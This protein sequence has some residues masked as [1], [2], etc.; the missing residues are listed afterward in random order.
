MTSRAGAFL[1][2]A[3]LCPS[4]R[5]VELG[6]ITVRSYVGQQL[7]ADIEL[8]SLAPDEVAGL[9]VR[10]ALPDVFSGANIRM[11][12]ALGTVHMSVVRRDQ[13]QFLH[14]TTLQA[15]D[16]NYI[17]L[18]L[19]LG[20]PGR[21]VVRAATVWLQPD[22]HPLPPPTPAY[23][24]PVPLSA[25]ASLA[26]GE[27]LDELP[28]PRT[29]PRAPAGGAA[30]HPAASAPA[31]APA[32]AARRRAAVA[33][34]ATAAA[35]AGAKPMPP[36]V[37]QDAG[38]AACVAKSAGLSAKECVALDYR[39]AALSTKLVELEDKVKVLQYA[40]EAP[41]AA[42][43]TPPPIVPARPPGAGVATAGAAAGHAAQAGGGHAAA[44]AAAVA[45]HT[46][47]A[48]A[49]VPATAPAAHADTAAHGAAA[50]PP[51]SAVA[52]AVDPHAPPPIVAA[53]AAKH[54]PKLKYSDK[55]EKPAEP[56][57][58]TGLLAAA[59]AGA[60]ALLLVLGGLWYV[61][62]RRK[63]AGMGSAPLKIWQGWRKKKPVE[64]EQ[65]L[66]EVMPEELLEQEKS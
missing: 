8:I 16:A 65:P 59:G 51:A 7:S 61:L 35:D 26:P 29:A 17:H 47:S 58:N 44:P 57:V 38:A 55:K 48:S 28:P 21:Q 40:L 41:A 62:R 53:P 45:P 25:R 36:P 64:A 1:L 24:A 10:L 63:A 43:K 54:L 37:R 23:A 30:R 50:T 2:A 56:A 22:P 6:D 14:V 33:A 13:R 27:E 9:P 42:G 20:A 4:V 18:F 49:A 60:A 32:L 11:N 39:N 52:A 12:P 34:A 46:E 66:P 31:P 15:V 3:L 19:E 5:A